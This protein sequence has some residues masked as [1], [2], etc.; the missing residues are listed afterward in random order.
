[1]T[2]EATIKLRPTIITK[3]WFGRFSLLRCCSASHRLALL[4][5][6]IQYFSHALESL[7]LLPVVPVIILIPG[8][9][10]EEMVWVWLVYLSKPEQITKAQHSWI[11][12]GIDGRS[13]V[14]PVVVFMSF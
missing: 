9:P 1:M 3:S 5:S 7:V 2:D 10:K 8:D 6:P 14:I 4:F 11:S 13:L 12:K